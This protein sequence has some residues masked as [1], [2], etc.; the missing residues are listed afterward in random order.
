[1]NRIYSVAAVA[2][3]G[4]S[5]IYWKEWQRR[6]AT[7]S[8][9]RRPERALGSAAG[10]SRELLSRRC[11]APFFRFGCQGPDIF[12]H[13]RRTM[14]SGLHYGALAHRRGFGSLVAGAAASLP[15]AEREATSASAAYL[16]GLATHAAVDRATHPFIIYFSG[17]ALPSD[18]GSGGFGA[19]T[20]SWSAS[21]TSASS[22]RSSG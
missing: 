3:K 14:P 5:A 21:S 13:N 15:A 11:G 6:S 18:P 7:S 12:Y 16:L 22:P 10:L 17:W 4:G 19:A 20:P 9:E 2:V 8:R 1:M